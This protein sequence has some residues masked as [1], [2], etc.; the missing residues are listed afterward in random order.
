VRLI[1]MKAGIRSIFVT[2]QVMLLRWPLQPYGVA[3]GSFDLD[4]AA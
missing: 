2:R 1:G 4:D 3:I